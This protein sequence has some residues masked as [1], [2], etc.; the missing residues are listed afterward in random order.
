ME[1]NNQ[2][3]IET[4]TKLIADIEEVFGKEKEEKDK[5]KKD[6]P[7]RE[8]LSMLLTACENFQI[9]EIEAAINEIE[10]FEYKSDDGLALWLR[11]N[12]DQMNYMEIVERLS[13]L[14]Q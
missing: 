11:E 7:Y 14:T 1:A 12:V 8:A 13:G 3:F 5:P 6:K 4:I 9:E 10:C 2:A